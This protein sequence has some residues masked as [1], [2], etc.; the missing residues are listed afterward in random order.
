MVLLLVGAFLFM[1]S[2]ETKAT[3]DAVAAGLVIG[4]A[5]GVKPSNGLFV[6]APVVAAL[7][8]R[9]LRPLLPFGLALLPALL[10]LAV[11]K[12]RGLGTLPAF[13][14]EETR[15]AAGAIVGRRSRRRPLRRSRLG[16]PG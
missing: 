6:G 1:R 16:A 12:Q 10:T 3:L 15:L 11:W 9:H 14:L 7:L 5:I 4:F 8:A 2:L 13:A